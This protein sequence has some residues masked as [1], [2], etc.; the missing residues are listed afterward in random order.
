MPQVGAWALS[1]P[2]YV[3]VAKEAAEDTLMAQTFIVEQRGNE[4]RTAFLNGYML[5][6]N[7]KNVPASIPAAQAYDSTYLLLYSLFARGGSLSGPAI[8]ASLENLE[9]LLRRG[10]HLRPPVQRQ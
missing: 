8:K 1:F 4:R 5:K 10:G 9:N 3:D 2:A 6:Y 7:L